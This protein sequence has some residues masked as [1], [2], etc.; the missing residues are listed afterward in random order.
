MD[1]SRD[2]SGSWYETALLGADPYHDPLNHRGQTPDRVELAPPP[3]QHPEPGCGSA[4]SNGH[5]PL[6][7][8]GLSA[9]R[10]AEGSA[11]TDWDKRD[12][13]ATQI[14]DRRPDPGPATSAGPGTDGHPARHTTRP[15]AV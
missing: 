10:R 6:L 7:S 12:A 14:G 2:R 8:A 1:A 4:R 3:T 5:R 15:R 11:P 9:C 13:A